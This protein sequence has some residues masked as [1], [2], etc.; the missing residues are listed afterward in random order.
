MKLI[1]DGI[2]KEVAENL[3][4]TY[5]GLGWNVYVSALMGKAVQ[6]K[7][8]ETEEPVKKTIIEK[9]RACTLKTEHCFILS[10]SKAESALFCRSSPRLISISQLHALLHFHP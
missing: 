4:A 3:V 6:E 7:K 1:K 9:L 2:V 5:L 8:A 10:K